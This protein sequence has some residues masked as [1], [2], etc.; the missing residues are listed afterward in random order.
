MV[1]SLVSRKPSLIAFDLDYTLW[2]FDCDDYYGTGLYEKDGKVYDESGGHVKP[3]SYSEAVLKCIYEEP[4][5]KLAVASSTSSPKV[6]LRLL[7]LLGWDKYFDYMEIYPTSKTRHFTELHSKSGIP[8]DQMLFF[9]DLMFNIRD[10]KKLGV[11]AV[12]V[13]KGVDLA[14][15]RK[16]LL[17]FASV[18]S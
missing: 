14:L 16:A 6:G 8:F 18:N 4:D 7:S 1:F 11:Y 17:D 5:V 13:Q 2:P 10:A 3:Y 9:D 15:L 12:P